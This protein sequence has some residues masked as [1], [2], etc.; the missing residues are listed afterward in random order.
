MCQSIK[1][2]WL[3]FLY[4]LAA[5]P[6]L[7]HIYRWLTEKSQ[8]EEEAFPFLRVFRYCIGCSPNTSA[9]PEHVHSTR[10]HTLQ[11]WALR[12]AFLTQCLSERG[13]SLDN[14]SE[15]TSVWCCTRANSMC[16]SSLISVGLLHV[17]ISWE[18]LHK[19]TLVSVP[20]ASPRQQS[21]EAKNM[22]S[23]RATGPSSSLTPYLFRCDLARGALTVIGS[24][25]SKISVASTW[26]WYLSFPVDGRLVQSNPS[27][28]R[29]WVRYQQHRLGTLRISPSKSFQPRMTEEK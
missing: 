9:L 7:Y 2:H 4:L 11:L 29:L 12:A 25:D 21:F 23:W 6:G 22:S 3:P 10:C 5:A 13:T 27:V 8:L 18:Y 16:I 26:I 19:P 17:S 1:E 14:Q 15:F 24:K 28:C 20:A